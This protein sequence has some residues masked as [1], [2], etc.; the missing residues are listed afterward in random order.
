MNI[1]LFWFTVIQWLSFSTLGL[2]GVV[3]ALRYRQLGASLRCIVW[4]VWFGIAMETVTH[5]LIFWHKPN[6]WLMP[7]DT[8]GEVLLL[9]LAYAP[10]LGSLGFSRWQPWVVGA[11]GVCVM[12]SSGLTPEMARFKPGIMLTGCLLELGL[13]ALYFRK[14]LNDLQV[15]NLAREPM[16]WV[17]TG[18]LIY[19]SSKVFIS[20]FSNYMLEH[21]SQQ[22]SLLVW[23]VHGLMTV[24]LYLCYL[25]AL[26]LRPQK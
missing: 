15:P 5:L 22:L 17:S 21:Y 10:A 6:L 23:A 26:W 8:L 25:R 7:V 3:G 9:S 4:L 16:F 12:L 13:A 20:L 14:L 19:A 24:V 1:E 2:V 18:V 11:F